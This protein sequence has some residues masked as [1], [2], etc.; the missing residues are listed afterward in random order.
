MIRMSFVP[1]LI[2][3][4]ILS[5]VKYFEIKTGTE[6]AGYGLVPRNVDSLF[7]LLTFPLIHDDAA[8]LYSN[9]LPLFILMA[10]LFFFYREVA[11]R[12]FILTWILH[13]VWLWIGGRPAFHIGASG[14]VYG[15]SSFLFFSGVWRRE[16]RM[17]AVS[18]TVVFLYGG[19]V[20]GLFPFFI[21]TSWEAHLFGALAGL[22]LSW[23][24]RHA[25]PQR[26]SYAW[27][28]EPDMEVPPEEQ[29]WN[30]PAEPVSHSGDTA[31]ASLDPFT[32]SKPELRYDYIQKDTPSESIQQ[33]NHNK[34]KDEEN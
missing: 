29:Y 8:H 23:A 19:M 11:W 20:W 15:L 34:Q 32:I 27:E 24:Y 6:L 2:F 16:R 10:M 4:L 33:E 30:L 26:T 1:G 5:L 12:V 17:M 22:V 9:I 14:I 13:A 18:L 31:P 28:T 7:H 21:G 25:G 3:V